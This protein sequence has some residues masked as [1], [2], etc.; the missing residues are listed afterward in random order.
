LRGG[1][2]WEAAYRRFPIL[3]G[4]SA[5]DCVF[6]SAAGKNAVA[7][8]GL[9]AIPPQNDLAIFWTVDFTSIAI[10]FPFPRKG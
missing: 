10:C 3:M 8:M 7:G 4:V 5:T 6:F 9:P 1:Q 2:K